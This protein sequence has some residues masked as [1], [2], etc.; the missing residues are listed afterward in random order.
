MSKSSLAQLSN[1]LTLEMMMSFINDSIPVFSLQAQNPEL[2]QLAIYQV[3]RIL[4]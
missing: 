1:Q 3:N 4:I 2:L